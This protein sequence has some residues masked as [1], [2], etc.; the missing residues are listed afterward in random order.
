MG[1]SYIFC[2][3]RKFVP[4]FVL[5]LFAITAIALSMLWEVP[6]WLMLERPQKDRAKWGRIWLRLLPRA[7]SHPLSS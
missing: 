3:I 1:I 7:Y 6:R 4:T 2:H 5:I